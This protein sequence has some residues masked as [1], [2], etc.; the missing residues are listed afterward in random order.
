MF[1][2]FGLKDDSI[3]FEGVQNAANP[4]LAFPFFASNFTVFLQIK[5]STN[6]LQFSKFPIVNGS[7]KAPTYFE[8]HFA[9]QSYFL[10][11]KP[12]CLKALNSTQIVTL[13]ASLIKLGKPVK[14]E[15]LFSFA[16][17]TITGDLRI[18]VCDGNTEL[19]PCKIVHNANVVPV[20][21]SAV[22]RLQISNNE[23]LVTVE[24]TLIT[25]PLALE[26]AGKKYSFSRKLISVQKFQNRWFGMSNDYVLFELS[27]SAGSTG[28]DQLVD[29]FYY[30][31]QPG[32]SYTEL[33]ATEN[34]MIGLFSGSSTDSLLYAGVT[35]F[36]VRNNNFFKGSPLRG[37]RVRGALGDNKKLDLF[38]RNYAYD[39]S[40][41]MKEYYEWKGN[42]VIFGLKSIMVL[43]VPPT[44]TP[45]LGNTLTF[46]TQGSINKTYSASKSNPIYVFPLAG[47]SNG[48]AM[49][50][51]R[52]LGNS[53]TTPSK[54][55][56]NL[57]QLKLKLFVDEIATESP[58]LNFE[59]YDD[60]TLISEGTQEITLYYNHDGHFDKVTYRIN[61]EYKK[62]PTSKLLTAALIG[63]V[64]LFVCF[65]I[66]CIL[67]SYKAIAKKKD[68]AS[69]YEESPTKLQDPLM[70]NSAGSKEDLVD[71]R[72][73]TRLK[74]ANF[75]QN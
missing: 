48:L 42:L 21:G 32:L 73:P 53:S 45:P 35:V 68:N 37:Q 6:S 12:G 50:S 20:E 15:N 13:Q 19:D 65:L 64:L 30:D 47:K 36:A 44:D 2:E 63:I 4:S 70:R 55:D 61:F 72:V 62:E 69:S 75:K 25:V 27:V 51:S 9:D 31:K 40:L 7:Y 39:R 66:L 26:L 5:K 57:S 49:L 22:E 28:E 74:V 24:S 43:A 71:K 46:Q 52:L 18:F 11:N 56:A 23:I 54:P 41:L 58:F 10:D 67:K 59:K 1:P 38:Y 8:Q 29:Q 33:Y 34:Y 14:G 60:E 3:S 16:T 17:V